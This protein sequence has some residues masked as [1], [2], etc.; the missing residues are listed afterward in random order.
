MHLVS[1]AALAKAICT[2]DVCCSKLD[3]DARVLQMGHDECV[4]QTA[5]PPFEPALVRH[6][7][8]LHPD[9]GFH[10]GMAQTTKS[11]SLMQFA[12]LSCRKCAGFKRE[13]AVCMPP[14][15]KQHIQ[16]GLAVQRRL[17]SAVVED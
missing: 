10:G 5:H 16:S 9:N 3:R 17:G 12:G 15:G 11:H 6:G 7:Q 8:Q 2:P 4:W 14:D 1:L 13:C